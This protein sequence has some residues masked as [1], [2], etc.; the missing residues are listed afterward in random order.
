MYGRESNQSFRPVNKKQQTN[1]WEGVGLCKVL[2]ELLRKWRATK[3]TPSILGLTLVES[4]LRT[5]GNGLFNGLFNAKGFMGRM[6]ESHSM[7][8]HVR[9]WQKRCWISDV[10]ILSGQYPRN[11]KGMVGKVS[12]PIGQ[13]TIFRAI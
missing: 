12:D 1:C 2:S 4:K 7:R 5:L 6:C 13:C 8:N 11:D 3:I 9:R 10:T